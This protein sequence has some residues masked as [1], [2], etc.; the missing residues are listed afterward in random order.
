MA[1]KTFTP[2]SLTT[3]QRHMYLLGM[4]NP[5]PICFASTINNNGE[6][7]LA[8]YSF[9][10]IFSSTP[11]IIIFSVSNRRDGTEKDTLKNVREN[12]ELVIN[13]VN[14]TISR[15]M[16]ICGIEYDSSISEFT[17]SGLTPIP[18]VMVKPPRVKESPVHFECKLIEIKKMGD[19]PGAANLIFAEIMLIHA[20][21]DIFAPDDTI[22]PEKLD[23]VGR[24]GNTNYCHINKQSVFPI[25][26]PQ[27]IIAKGFDN[28]P[29]HLLTSNIL[30]GNQLAMLAGVPELPT[31]DQVNRFAGQPEIKAFLE[32]LNRNPESFYQTLHSKISNYLDQGDTASAWMLI[33]RLEN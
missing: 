2:D 26:Q 27:G 8:P 25:V 30:T 17:K 9:F 28:L 14:Y 31:A 16:A 3:R 15:Q 23:I 13:M 1:I 12:G 10:N 29:Q 32:E 6:Y 18:S 7:N 24:L 22:D 19:H 5:R 20:D 21:E 33:K 11:P 4:I